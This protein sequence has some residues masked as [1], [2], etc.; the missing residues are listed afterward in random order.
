MMHILYLIKFIRNSEAHISFPKG[1]FAPN[2]ENESRFKEHKNIIF[3][4]EWE[5]DLKIYKIETGNSK[6][7]F[8]SGYYIKNLYNMWQLQYTKKTD[9]KWF[10]SPR[11]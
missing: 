4:L 10:W 5:N 8:K 7:E 9:I 2:F 6:L 3:W 1:I 11:P